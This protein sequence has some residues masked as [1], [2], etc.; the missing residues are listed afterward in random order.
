MRGEE[1]IKGRFPIKTF[2]S[3]YHQ[4][5]YSWLKQQ[6]EPIPEEGQLKFSKHWIQGWM[7]EHR[8]SLLKLNKRFVIKNKYRVSRKDYLKNIWTLKSIFWIFFPY[9]ILMLMSYK[10]LKKR[11]CVFLWLCLKVIKLVKKWLEY[12]LISCGEEV[13]F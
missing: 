12:S 11:T 6:T 2:W 8:V 4:V 1:A 7:R 13:L 3:K 5:Y 9:F 10:N